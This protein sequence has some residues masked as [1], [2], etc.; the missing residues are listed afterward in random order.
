MEYKSRNRCSKPCERILPLNKTIVSKIEKISQDSLATAGA[1]NSRPIFGYPFNSSCLTERNSG[2]ITNEIQIPARVF[3][4]QEALPDQSRQTM[5]CQLTL[6]R[7]QGAQ[8]STDSI[9]NQNK[10]AQQKSG[11]FESTFISQ[12]FCGGCP[13]PVPIINET[14]TVPKPKTLNKESSRKSGHRMHTQKKQRHSKR[15]QMKMQ[16]QFGDPNGMDC[17][18]FN[19]FLSSSS[20]SSSD[21]EAAETNE[22][23]REGDDELTDWP[24]NEAMV[25]FASKNDFKR[26]KPQR[27]TP[28]AAKNSLLAK[29]Y[30]D[31]MGQDDDTLMSADELHISPNPS[32]FNRNSAEGI[33]VASQL[34]PSSLNLPLKFSPA[35]NTPSLSTR[36]TTSL[37]IDITPSA[38]Q[39]NTFLTNKVEKQLESEMSGETS[40]PLLSSPGI[41]V[42]EIRAGCRRVHDDRPGFTIFTSVNEHLSR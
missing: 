8:Q 27:S 35:I 10:L 1:N 7:D 23:D 3:K 37:P 4:P 2:S 9:S 17:E 42:R 11:S 19:D 28:M 32:P 5:D 14:G 16:L 41:E 26:A 22:S 29:G 13:C 36:Q 15:L 39:Y 6:Q 24:G 20:L 12:D 21:S 34:P 18:N 38:N 40:N 31:A 30:D 33:A 25:N